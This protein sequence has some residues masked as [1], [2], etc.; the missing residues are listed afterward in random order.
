MKSKFTQTIASSLSKRDFVFSV[1]DIFDN[2]TLPHDFYS[3]SV[4]HVQMERRRAYMVEGE[5]AIR[6]SCRVGHRYYEPGE[7]EKTEYQRFSSDIRANTREIVPM[8]DPIPEVLQPAIL[9]ALKDAP[10]TEEEVELSALEEDR[11]RSTLK[12]RIFDRNYTPPGPIVE[13]LS[14][15]GEVEITELSIVDVPFYFWHLRYQKYDIKVA[16]AAIKGAT[17][18]I[19]GL[20]VIPSQSKAQASIPE[21][22]RRRR[23]TPRL[24][25]YLGIFPVLFILIGTPM[26]FRYINKDATLIAAGA[27]LAGVGLVGL[28]GVIFRIFFIKQ[29]ASLYE[30]QE[31]DRLN[32]IKQEQR[33][34][35][36]AKLEMYH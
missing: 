14:K 12:D 22:A 21:E 29:K 27:I 5:A 31:K 16:C 33:A 18:F 8:D 19:E 17:P 30:I 13:D 3:L 1:A 34:A 20:D 15:S 7:G 25:R 32:K 28:I 9:E 26:I 36:R 10:K 11:C 2:R 24:W 23:V 4:D 6:F 35:F